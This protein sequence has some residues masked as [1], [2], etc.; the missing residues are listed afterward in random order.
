MKKRFW[1]SEYG[2]ETQLLF[3][4]FGFAVAHGGIAS[5]VPGMAGHQELF[6]VFYS[7]NTQQEA[8][9]FLETRGSFRFL[10]LQTCSNAAIT[11]SAVRCGRNSRNP[12]NEVRANVF[13]RAKVTNQGESRG[14]PGN[15]QGQGS[16]PDN[17]RHQ[18]V[19]CPQCRLELVQ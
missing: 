10:R 5:S 4:R 8:G 11:A 7:P 13:E 12:R 3:P 2:D 6:R 18:L 14:F 1:Q 17:R 16:T 15:K 9:L 19:W